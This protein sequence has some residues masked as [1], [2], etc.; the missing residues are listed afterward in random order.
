MGMHLTRTDSALVRKF[1]LLRQQLNLYLKHF[2]SHEKFALTNRIRNTADTVYEHIITGSMQYHKKTTLTKLNESHELLRAYIYEAYMLGYFD[3]ADKRTSINPD[4]R[5][6]CISKLIDEVGKM[7]GAWI[8][9]E[10]LK[11]KD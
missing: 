3:W 6:M 7:I 4:D 11:A 1:I 5:Y 8:N 2:P 10:Q 9:K